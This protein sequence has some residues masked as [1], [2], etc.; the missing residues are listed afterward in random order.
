[1]AVHVTECANKCRIWIHIGPRK[2]R[3]RDCPH[4]RVRAADG[5]RCR[6][7]QILPRRR[8]Q[9][10]LA[11]PSMGPTVPDFKGERRNEKREQKRSH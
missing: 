9:P 3:V 4:L 6:W 11:R 5:F 7:T 8:S 2:R 1:M 10:C